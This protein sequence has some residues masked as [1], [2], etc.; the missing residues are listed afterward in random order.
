MMKAPLLPF[1]LFLALT[2][3]AGAQVVDCQSAW[4]DAGCYLKL[5]VAPAFA[6]DMP[7]ATFT[8]TTRLFVTRKGQP[9]AKIS[10]TYDNGWARSRS[11][12]RMIQRPDGAV[13]RVIGRFRTD[14]R[15]VV[16]GEHGVF[17]SLDD[18]GRF[19]RAGGT[20]IYSL[21]LPTLELASVKLET[22]EAT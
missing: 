16:C 13:H 11:T 5:T 17:G 15:A 1:G 19:V 21:S 22:C 12:A 20:V 9:G 2:A 4:Q 18:A 3:P 6:E 7:A 14:M 10:W 8:E